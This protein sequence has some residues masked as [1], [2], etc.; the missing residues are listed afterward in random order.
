MSKRDRVALHS[1]ELTFPLLDAWRAR[2][3]SPERPDRG[4]EL[5]A[6]AR[7]WPWHP[8]YEVARQSLIAAVQH[9]NLARTAIA[10]HEVYPT[11]HF[12]VLRGALVGAAQGVWLLSPDD[13]TERQQRA[14]R[15]IDE[16]YSRRTQYNNAINPAGLSDLDQIRLRDQTR[17]LEERRRQARCLWARTET[18]RAAETLNL[19]SVI[20]WASADTFTDP[21]QQSDTRLLWNMMS[22]DAHALGWPLALR[23]SEWTKES[24]GLGVAA[25]PGDLLDIAQPYVASFR[26][27]RRGWS[28]FDRRAEGAD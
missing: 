10:A 7:I 27:L 26:L 3:R 22:G 17:H 18:L 1:I 9:L 14:L 24:D 2:S 11:S 20:T 16:W 21:G 8:P 28:L 13:T 4:S 6:D 5:E 19:T 15:V 12:T 23:G 25:A